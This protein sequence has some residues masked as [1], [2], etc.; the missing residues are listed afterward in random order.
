MALILLE[1][2]KYLSPYEEGYRA[3]RPDNVKELLG[4]FSG[5]GHERARVV[6]QWFF[7]AEN[8]QYTKILQRLWAPFQYSQEQPD[9]IG[10]LPTDLSSYRGFSW[11]GGQI[12]ILLT[13]LGMVLVKIFLGMS[14][15]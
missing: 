14:T 3:K 8:I 1:Q 11:G 10:A 15:A 13:G 5:W 4:F 12:V 6:I 7:H 2:C 9:S